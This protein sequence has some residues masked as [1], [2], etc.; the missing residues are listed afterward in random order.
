MVAVIADRVLRSH[1]LQR[2][3]RLVQ[4]DEATLK[5]ELRTPARGRTV[6]DAA[7]EG[8]TQRQQTPRDRREEFCLALLFR[9]P[10]ARA[11]GELLD[12]DLFGHSENRALF[13]SWV[14]WADAGE[15]FDESLTPDLR[16]QY[17]RVFNLDLP[18]YDD[19][20]VIKALHSTVWRI[21]QQ[22]L[23]YAKRASGAVLA[24]IAVQD[25]ALVAERAHS[26]W[27]AGRQTIEYTTEDEADPA[28]AFVEDMEAGLKVHQRLLEQ[29]NAE[30]PAR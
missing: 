23:R 25:A 8:H 4:V 10:L 29:H 19:D 21:E 11:E 13:E 12:P 1:Y 30:R 3:A 17:E 5:L 28:T 27:A 26:T 24:D 9:Y 2:L 14:G 6:R 16:P 18:A 15:S 20:S 22:R 7:P